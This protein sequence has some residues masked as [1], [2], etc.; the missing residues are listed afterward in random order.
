[1]TRQAEYWGRVQNFSCEVVQYKNGT[2][3]PER[4]PQGV[5]NDCIPPIATDLDVAEFIS[6]CGGKYCE[7]GCDVFKSQFLLS[8]I[9]ASYS[10]N[11]LFSSPSFRHPLPPPGTQAPPILIFAVMMYFMKIPVNT[12]V[13][14]YG[15]PVFSHSGL[16]T[17]IRGKTRASVMEKIPFVL[18]SL[19]S[20]GGD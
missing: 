7:P 5:A 14:Q 1:M 4:G 3:V 17:Y 19:S 8:K 13:V 20:I 16:I 10:V 12:I 15:E 18:G 2:V 6:K 9:L 11:K